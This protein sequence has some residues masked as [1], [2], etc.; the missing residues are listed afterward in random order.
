MGL[1]RGNSN[2]S[3]FAASRQAA[4]SSAVCVSALLAGAGASFI[5]ARRLGKDWQGALAAVPVRG[6]AVPS[7][8]LSR[9]FRPCGDRCRVPVCARCTGPGRMRT[10]ARSG[11][12]DIRPA[13]RKGWYRPGRSACGGWPA[14]H[15]RVPFVSLPGS[16]RSHSGLVV[17]GVYGARCVGRD[18]SPVVKHRRHRVKTSPCVLRCRGVA[19]ACAAGCRA[20]GLR[21]RGPWG[22]TA[23]AVVRVV[24][25]EALGYVRASG[26]PDLRQPPELARV[27][28]AASDR[29]ASLHEPHLQALR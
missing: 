26:K 15:V 6:P 17:G 8:R 16:A 18:V 5:L 23:S 21:F 20:G 13:D 2:S 3:C 7:S 4:S 9:R 12:V 22:D 29:L 24:G 14:R 19:P 1:R 27:S 11:T 28:D 25:D 10:P